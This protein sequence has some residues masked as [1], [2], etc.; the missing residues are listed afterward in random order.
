M[1]PGRMTRTKLQEED[2]KCGAVPDED[3]TKKGEKGTAGLIKYQGTVRG[4]R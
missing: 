3:I 2:R 1:K 4:I